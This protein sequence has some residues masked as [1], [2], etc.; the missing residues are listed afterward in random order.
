MSNEMPGD[1]SDATGMSEQQEAS[2]MNQ[3]RD[4]T[5]TNKKHRA[6]GIKI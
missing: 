4:K 1:M 6:K 5:M 2:E 3:Q